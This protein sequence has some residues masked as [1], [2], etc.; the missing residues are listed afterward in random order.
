MYRE[1]RIGHASQLAGL[2]IDYDKGD[3]EEIRNA[4]ADYRRPRPLS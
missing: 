4:M 3:Q 1:R 2:A